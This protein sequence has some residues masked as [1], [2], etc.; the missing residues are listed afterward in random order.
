MSHEHDWR[1]SPASE[2][3]RQYWRILL[4]V[5][6]CVA[7]AT[8]IW[9]ALFPHTFWFMKIW[10]GFATG[11]PVG[12]IP[13]TWWQL[14]DK[15]R[16][17]MLSGRYLVVFVMFSG[18]VSYDMGSN[19]YAQEGQRSRIRSLRVVDISSIAIALDG[20]PH[21]NIE[22]AETIAEFVALS[23]RAEL[24]YPSHEVSKRDFEITIH[25]ADRRMLQF[26]GGVPERHQNDFSFQI[27][28]PH[29]WGIIFPRGREWLDAVLDEN[30]G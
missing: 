1:T 5:F 6:V 21:R 12:M 27:L 17:P 10:T 25:L 28:G 29:S 4:C 15:Q 18:V 3:I 24:F 14:R 30:A 11:T 9:Q 26:F 16:R 23:E 20:Q 13:G 8:I 22:D 19:F 2:M 7:I